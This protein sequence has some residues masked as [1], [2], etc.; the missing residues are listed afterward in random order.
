VDNESVARSAP[1][2]THP[3]HESRE[4]RSCNGFGLV[5]LDAEYDFESGELT[6]ESTECPICHGG[7]SVSIYLYSVPRRHG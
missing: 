2:D 5:L 1:P 3:D 7:G 6:Q 4:C